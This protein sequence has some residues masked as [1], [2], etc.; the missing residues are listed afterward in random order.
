MTDPA[1][2][3]SPDPSGGASAETSPGWGLAIEVSNPS[4]AVR[5]FGPSVA[6]ARGDEV[7]ASVPVGGA[8]QRGSDDLFPA[9]ER[10]RE[11]AGVAVDAL[12]TVVVS[13]GPGGLT[14]LRVSVA[15]AAAIAEARGVA[16]VGVPTSR[17][18]AVDEPAGTGI[19]LASKG[20]RAWLAVVGNGGVSDVG[21]VDAGELGGQGLSRLVCDEHLPGRWREVAGAMGLELV[22][23]R[24]S[25]ERLWRCRGSV[26]A[27]DAA[28]LRVLY[29]REPEA[30][31]VWRERRG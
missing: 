30:V 28:A 31:R 11:R 1:V 3:A 17:V 4:A 22:P 29:P 6:V 5:G 18:A 15:A 13:I 9:I 21:E 24:L 7:L 27:C 25:A 14:G 2:N 26:A 19:A 16:C 20:E 8:G 10:A 23:T 12:E